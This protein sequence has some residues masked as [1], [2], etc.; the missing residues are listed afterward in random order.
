[1]RLRHVTR[2][3]FRPKLPYRFDL[4]IRKPAGWSWMTPLEI[5]DKGTLWTGTW[6][7]EAP[8]GLK[9]RQAG[10]TVMVDLYAKR[11]LKKRE[12]SAF[13]SRLGRSLGVDEDL[14][15]LYALMRKD[16]MLSKLAHRLHGMHEGWG[17]DLFP[18]LQ[19]AVLLQM[20]PIKRSQDMWGCLI[21]RHGSTLSF[22][23]KAVRTW[24]TARTIAA[25][26]AAHL[27][28]ECRLG[29][30]AKS[31]VRIAKRLVAG[32]PTIEDLAGMTP[33]AAQ[34]KLMELYG[35]GE[36]SAAF[37]T[38]HPSFSVDVWSVKLFHR[39]LFGKPAPRK[40]P[41]SAI[42]KVTREAVRRWG[43]WRG[44]VFTYVLNDLP[45]LEKAF[46]ISAVT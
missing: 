25:R 3:E 28:K 31:L 19:L 5:W 26:S 10:A 40:D 27:A 33:D 37:A 12:L 29:Y 9:V 21:E 16:R 39:I 15:P 17:F 36:Y 45:Y 24:P 8:I 22:D 38:P 11:S 20:A 41:R 4:T 2:F 6:F 42:E 18:S 7:G 1:M 46:G 23:G 44:Y 14:R 13:K 32:F 35:V 34:E 30:R 43:E